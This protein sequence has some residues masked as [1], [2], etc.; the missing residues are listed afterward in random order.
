MLAQLLHQQSKTEEVQHLLE[1]LCTPAE[2]AELDR[3][4]KIVQMLKAGVAQRD[5]ADKLHVG[6]ATVTRGSRE[7]QLGRFA[8]VKP[9]AHAWRGSSH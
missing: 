1:G 4:L 5:I 6:I 2:L 8:Q 7:L 3:R 9:D